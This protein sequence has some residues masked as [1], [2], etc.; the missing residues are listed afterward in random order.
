MFRAGPGMAEW[1][2]STGIGKLVRLATPCRAGLEA[3]LADLVGAGNRRAQPF[4]GCRGLKRA[5]S[6]QRMYP[7]LSKIPTS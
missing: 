6:H 7:G 5:S 3:T 4:E 2:V 1:K